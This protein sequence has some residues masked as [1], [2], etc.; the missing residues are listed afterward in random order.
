M[1][2]FFSRNGLVA[3]V[4][5]LVVGCFAWMFGSQ[6]LDYMSRNSANAGEIHRSAENPITLQ[7]LSDDI[8]TL[9]TR[10][11]E[12]ASTAATIRRRID[13]YRKEHSDAR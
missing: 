2:V 11:N 13:I 1:S 9:T 8:D 5:I 4:L 6:L 7:E 3:T 10:A 12:M